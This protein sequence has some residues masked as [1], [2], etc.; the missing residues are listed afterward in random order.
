MKLKDIV[1]ESN[2]GSSYKYYNSYRFLSSVDIQTLKDW[3]TNSLIPFSTFKGSVLFL[4]DTTFPRYKFT[5]YSRSNNQIVK[6]VREVKNADAVIVNVNAYKQFL[7]DIRPSI[8]QKI[9]EEHG[10]TKKPLYLHVTANQA[11]C[12]EGC[13][14]YGNNN[15]LENIIDN[16]NNYNHLKILSVFDVQDHLSKQ[17]S[18]IDKARADDLDKLLGSTDKES[19]KLGM[20]IMTNS[21]IEGSLLYIMLMC[22]KHWYNMRFNQYTAS[23]NWKAFRKT[24]ESFGLYQHHIEGNNS[25]DQTIKNFLTLKNKFIM[26]DDIP[27][28]KSCI[29]EEVERTF[30][31]SSTGFKINIQSIDLQLDEDK[32]IKKAQETPE[33]Q[34]QV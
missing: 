10:D 8:I 24:L 29:S 30:N 21:D 18:P 14:V 2:S 11:F 20:E 9:S 25:I 16:Y 32:I 22:N 12:E 28:I 33:L 4:K 19:V 27:Y 1:I 15:F 5:E 34:E 26:E 3:V 31:F 13:L 6:R 17:Y 23:T 7:E